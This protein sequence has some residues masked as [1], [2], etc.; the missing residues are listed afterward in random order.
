MPKTRSRP[1]HYFFFAEAY[2]LISMPQ[3][4]SEIFGVFQAMMGPP[5]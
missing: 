1:V 3:A 2:M 4:T 5:V